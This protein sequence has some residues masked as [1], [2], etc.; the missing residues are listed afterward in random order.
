MDIPYLKVSRGQ[1]IIN[2]TLTNVPAPIDTA[3]LI[4]YR[5][6]DNVPFAAYPY[7][8]V[9]GSLDRVTLKFQ[10]DELLFSRAPGRYGAK[11][12]INGK[13]RETFY[14]QYESNESISVRAG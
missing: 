4:I 9:V 2:C 11:L 6:G 3:E 1:P 7:T 10:F 13:I 5:V 8:S 12:D 14:F